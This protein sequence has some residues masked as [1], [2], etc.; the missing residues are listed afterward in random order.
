M[1]LQGLNAHSASSGRM[2]YAQCL[3]L[4]LCAMRTTSEGISMGITKEERKN[5]NDLFDNLFITTCDVTWY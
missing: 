2:A 1:Q 4:L 3:K 5:N